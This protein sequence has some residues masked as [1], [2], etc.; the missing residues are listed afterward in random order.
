MDVPKKYWWVIGIAVPVIIAIISILPNLIP[1]KASSGAFYVDVVGTQF[2]GQVAINNVSVVA[3]QAR[4]KLGGELPK[5][6]LEMLS[7][8]IELTQANNFNAAIPVLESVAKAAPVPAVFN[9]LGAA[10]L[11][12]G[13]KAK[14][15]N[16][17]D[18]ALAIEPDQE[19]ARFN[20]S[21]TDPVP[22]NG[23]PIVTELQI[24]NS[25]EVEPNNE[26]LTPNTIPLETWID[27]V[28]TEQGD[29][30]YYRF[31]SPAT[32]RDIILISIENKSTT[33]IPQIR[34]FNKNKADISGWKSNNTEGSN[35]QYSFSSAP[36]ET[37]Y[38]QL[39][40]PYG[41]TNGAYKVIIKPLKSYDNY[42]P[43]DNIL[44]AKL[45]SLGKPLDASKMD[46]LD[47]D[48]YRFKTSS[49]AGTVKILIENKSTTLVP[50]LRVF[51]QEK[52]DISG[53]QSKNTAGANLTYSFVSE[54]SSTYYLVITSPYGS[55]NGSYTLTVMEEANN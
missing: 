54:P 26:I 33:L 28:K 36:N 53:W 51:N 22:A 47:N 3:E 45:I 1:K 52:S 6:V 31:T 16:A 17:F 29:N 32:Y 50:Q 55:T 43:N 38:V 11:A 15:A 34:V 13:N 49:S 41:T 48:Y 25:S 5:E 21:Q 8:A 2:N 7:K 9:N 19:S 10:Y 18:K 4:E 40:S 12:T 30:D 39:T 24:N 42:E 14:A 23:N 44:N 35:L 27:G 37:Y 46:S 20:L